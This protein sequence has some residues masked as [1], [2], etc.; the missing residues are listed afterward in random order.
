MG[1]D[2]AT[3]V[4]SKSNSN[5]ILH[6]PITFFVEYLSSDLKRETTQDVVEKVKDTVARFK[7]VIDYTPDSF[8]SDSC[9]GTSGIECAPCNETCSKTR[10]SNG[11]MSV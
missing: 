6:T 4:L 9:N 2:G 8:V 1:I 10:F 11:A 3:N 7:D 5:V